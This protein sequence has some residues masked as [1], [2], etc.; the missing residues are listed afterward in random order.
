[1]YAPPGGDLSMR[2]SFKPVRFNGGEE[3]QTKLRIISL[4]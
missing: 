4:I 3:I 1:M 2:L